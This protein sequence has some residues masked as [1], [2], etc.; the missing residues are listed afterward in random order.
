MLELSPLAKLLG[1]FKFLQCT[2]GG[3][4]G[5]CQE[6]ALAFAWVPVLVCGSLWVEGRPYE[7]MIHT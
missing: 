1:P 7:F 5:G 4:L 6:N 2:E 3:F